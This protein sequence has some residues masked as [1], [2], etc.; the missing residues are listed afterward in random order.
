MRGHK[1]DYRL[2]VVMY[3]RKHIDNTEQAQQHQ[4][5]MAEIATSRQHIIHV[6]FVVVF[7]TPF[8]TH[9]SF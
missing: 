9:D 8:L 1:V 3:R 5:I 6:H 4:L 7:L 2:R